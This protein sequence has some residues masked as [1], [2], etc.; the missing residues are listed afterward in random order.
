MRNS[1]NWTQLCVAAL[2]AV[3]GVY[4]VV[5]G[6]SYDVGSARNI[7]PGFFP[8]AL[9]VLMLVIVVFVA[10]EGMREAAIDVL[11]VPRPLLAISAGMTGFA[12]ALETAGLIP[13][14]VILVLLSSLAEGPL[15]AKATLVNAVV[16]SVIGVL[17]FIEAFSLPLP[18]I[19]W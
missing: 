9:G 13:A 8:V 11:W 16:L 15:R 17:L 5:S 19:N 12:L 4:V 1:I 7:G 2:L 6:L 18:A 3:T 14:T 10:L